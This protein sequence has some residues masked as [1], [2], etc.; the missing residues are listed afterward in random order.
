[1]ATITKT[2]GS[3]NDVDY[4]VGNSG[5]DYLLNGGAGND[6]LQVAPGSGAVTIHGGTGNDTISG[7]QGGTVLDSNGSWLYGDDGND[8]IYAAPLWSDEVH[9]FGG[10]GNDTIYANNFYGPVTLA[11]GAGD[12][13]YDIKWEDTSSYGIYPV[14]FAE[15]AA[16]G[17]DRIRLVIEHDAD[18]QMAANIEDLE[19][20]AIWWDNVGDDAYD[21]TNGTYE[22]A[23]GSGGGA[24]IAG[25]T[26]ANRITLSDRNDTAYGSDGADTILGGVGHDHLFGEVGADYLTG[27]RHNDTLEGGYGLD[28]LYG[29]A[30]HDLLL[31]G[32]GGDLLGGDAGQDTL[33]GGEG[34]DKLYGSADADSLAGGN[35]NDYLSGDAGADTMVG[36]AGNDV[37]VVDN[38]GDK[39]IEGSGGG[40]DRVETSLLSYSLGANVENLTLLTN[41]GP[42]V[43]RYATGN[44]L[45]N[46]IEAKDGAYSDMHDSVQGGA[47]W[48]YIDLGK[49]NDTGFGGADGDTIYGREGNDL[50]RGDDGLDVLVGGAGNDQVEGGTGADSLYGN[51]G[52]DTVLGGDGNDSISGGA[53]NDLLSGG[54]GADTIFGDDGNDTIYGSAAADKLS[55]GA[56]VDYFSYTSVSD[57]NAAARDTIIDFIK[58]VDKINLSPMDADST[59][60]GNQAF[61]FTGTGAM[62]SS[63]GDLWIKEALIGTVVYGDVNGDGNADFQLLAQGVFGLQASDFIL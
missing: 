22:G 52:N 31:G 34:D 41:Y 56:G 45:S 59:T 6:E 55:G 30:D 12:D 60:A 40:I 26:L 7:R 54:N 32:D 10:T 39:V 3:G 18:F 9:A 28:T 49:G 19:I 11:G 16:A 4:V 33:D 14:T 5:D 43:T 46:R 1:M 24:F 58:G 48:D 57:S 17:R 38:A 29:G 53:E 15:D 27:G 44:S 20:S 50:L 62:F 23:A 51:A 63:P 61:G 47:G 37:Y 36:G 13:L 35:G 42:S 8:S 2:Y 25:N 21:Y